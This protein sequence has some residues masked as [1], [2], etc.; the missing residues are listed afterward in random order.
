MD[1]VSS[2]LSLSVS[3]RAVPEWVS[4]QE[5]VLV[6]P[7]HWSATRTPTM[8][9]GTTTTTTTIITTMKQTC[10]QLLLLLTTSTIKGG[11]GNTSSNWCTMAC[12]FC[13]LPDQQ[14]SVVKLISMYWFCK[15]FTV[16][17]F[18]DVFISDFLKFPTISKNTLYCKGN[19][20]LMH[21]N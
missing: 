6:F 7:L 13:F 5:L 17:I 20:F 11:I 3:V 4:V 19:T 15:S 14:Q 9:M 12:P 16:V 2:T 21:P 8:T 1:E 18:I 10:L